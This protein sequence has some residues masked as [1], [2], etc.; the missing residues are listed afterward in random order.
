MEHCAG[1]R[2]RLL[3]LLLVVVAPVRRPLSWNGR[4]AKIKVPQNCGKVKIAMT[5]GGKF[6]VWNGKQG[7]HEF[8]IFCRNRKQAAELVEIIN[9]KKHKGEVI[10]EG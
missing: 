2:A 10:V 3:L 6:S 9:K 1:D 7:Q 5:L 4:M 8:V